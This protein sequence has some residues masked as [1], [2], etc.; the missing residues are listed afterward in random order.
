M[1]KLYNPSIIYD[2]IKI[3][4]NIDIIPPVHVVNEFFLQI[5]NVTGYGNISNYSNIFL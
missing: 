1:K 4:I 5:F 3:I 2:I